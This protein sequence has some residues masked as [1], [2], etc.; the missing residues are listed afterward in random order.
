MVR[1]SGRPAAPAQLVLS[2]A[3]EP[4]KAAGRHARIERPAVSPA[5]I[6]AGDPLMVDEHTDVSE[7]L[8]EATALRAAAIGETVLVRLKMGQA[9]LRARVTAPGRGSLLAGRSEAHR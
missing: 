4:S 5:V 9:I 3:A 7:G 8:L 2:C 1:D 6:H